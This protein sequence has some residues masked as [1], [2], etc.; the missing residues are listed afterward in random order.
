MDHIHLKT[1]TN[2]RANQKISLSERMSLQGYKHLGEYNS[3]KHFD[4][5]SKILENNESWLI[6]PEP[7]SRL[8]LLKTYICP[9]FESTGRPCEN[10]LPCI[11]A[12]GVEELRN[13]DD[14]ITKQSLYNFL[15]YDKWFTVSIYKEEGDLEKKASII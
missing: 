11:K 8:S 6:F 5:I 15:H 4:D 14:P 12:H 3:P 2:S 13:V 9:F 7:K 1:S 10:P